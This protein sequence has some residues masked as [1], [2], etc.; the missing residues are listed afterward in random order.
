MQSDFSA[1]LAHS[2]AE[3][4]AVDPELWQLANVSEAVRVLSAYLLDSR[5]PVVV[6]Q[7]HLLSA[8]GRSVH[9]SRFPVPQTLH[10]NF[11]VEMLLDQAG[12]CT[13]QPLG[14][15]GRLGYSAHHLSASCA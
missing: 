15:L 3:R 5:F 11:V 7:K 12:M 13:R 9:C 1:Q 10:R 2:I 6:L 8:S 4:L 14:Y